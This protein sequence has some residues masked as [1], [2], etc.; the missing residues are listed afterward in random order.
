MLRAIVD[1]NGLQRIL[2]DV[3][4]CVIPVQD[5]RG[6]DAREVDARIGRI[7]VEMDH[8]LYDPTVWP[9]FELR[10]T[11]TAQGALLHFSIDLLMVDITSTSIVLDELQRAYFDNDD[12][13]APGRASGTMS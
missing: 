11:S 13:A 1:V 5:L 12:P 8:R 9:L 2:S 6:L 3:P 7:R 4:A 10:L